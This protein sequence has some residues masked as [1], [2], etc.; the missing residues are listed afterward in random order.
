MRREALWA[1]ERQMKKEETYQRNVKLSEA[2]QVDYDQLKTRTIV[3]LGK[4]GHQKFSSEPG[5]YSLENW[6]R[7]V[8]LL[9]DD[10]E[11][12]M[13]AARLP[14]DYAE[15][16]RELT[17]WLSKPVDLS[18]IDNSISEHTQ[19]EQEIVRKLHEARTRN[20]SRID[21][22]RTE[23]A[24]RS[25]ELEEKK[26]QLSSLASERRSDSIFKRLF[27]GNSTLAVNATESEVEEIES[28]LRILASGIL[29]AQK[30]LK[31]IDK[32]SESP[33]AEEWRRLESLQA[34]R[35]EL[36]NERLEKSQLV[37]EREELTASIASTISKIPRVEEKGE[38]AAASSS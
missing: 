26:K 13:G 12:K 35:K 21:E 7:G 17:H 2:T 36:E 5:G 24:T 31:S 1:A 32:H 23:L 22:L 8:N 20:S 34:K 38:G 11:E 18:S 14:S 29:E 28:R 16:R 3:A 30:S 15:R 33:W 27:G 9:L 37:R 10:F 6:V 19:N 4:L 25:A